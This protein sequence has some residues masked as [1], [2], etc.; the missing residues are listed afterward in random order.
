M[1]LSEKW[2]NILLT[3]KGNHE[4]KN[5]Y[6][7][8]TGNEGRKCNYPAR[9]DTYGKGC[10][11]DCSYC[12]VKSLLDFR[13]LW[14]PQNPSVADT[15]RI[16]RRIELIQ[17]RRGD[18]E[19]IVIRL[20]G[21]TDCFQPCEK[22]HRVTYETIKALNK[23][24]I[25]YLIVTK[26]ALVADDEYITVMD[27][28][29]AHI[30]VTITTLDDEL[31]KTYE[32]CSSPSERVKAIEK[33]AEAGFDVC[34]RLSPFIP[35]YMDMNGL[36]KIK[37]DKILVEFLRVNRWVEEWFDIDCSEYTLK[38]KGY[39]H[40]PLEKKLEYIKTVKGFKEITVCEDEDK[41]YQYW[42]HHFNPNRNDCC[43]LKGYY[44]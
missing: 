3:E 40:L 37:C 2:R 11:H 43:N 39:R 20:G 1:I 24:K 41:A 22:T 15:E 21:M 19:R 30:Q 44:D 7:V 23:A 27:K 31:A 9:L 13:G 36:A 29:L 34:V 28:D 38:H 5:F 35:Q 18:G 10:A 14:N 42:K 16:K 6:K 26:S 33:L 32:H 12:Y 25:E 4:Y 8:V 17:K